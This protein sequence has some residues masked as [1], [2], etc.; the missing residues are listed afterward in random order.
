MDHVQYT[1][2][3]ILQP[4][5]FRPIHSPSRLT[6]I[7]PF[8]VNVIYYVLLRPLLAADTI[9]VLIKPVTTVA[10]AIL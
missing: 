5:R 10:S 3:T 9:R 7:S 1:I 2:M 4:E 6:K 8:K